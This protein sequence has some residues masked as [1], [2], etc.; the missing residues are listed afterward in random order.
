MIPW[1]ALVLGPIMG[2]FGQG[3]TYTTNTGAVVNLPDGVF[4][5]GTAVID[6]PGQPGILSSQPLLGVRIV[7]MPA[8]WDPE[9]AQGDRFTLAN[10]AL[11][12]VK[13]A[14]ADSHGFV[15]IEANQI[16]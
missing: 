2:V 3:I 8:G 15:R 9:L 12:E 10:G 13:A 11:Y 7:R 1:D 16:L 5:Q 4:D 14:K 6:V